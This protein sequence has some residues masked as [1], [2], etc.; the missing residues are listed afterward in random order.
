MSGVLVALEMKADP[1]ILDSDGLTPLDLMFMGSYDEEICI[2]SYASF[3]SKWIET[4]NTK[5]RIF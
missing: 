2:K 5:V 1:N 4:R 3:S